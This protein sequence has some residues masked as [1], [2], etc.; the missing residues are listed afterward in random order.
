MPVIDAYGQRR[1]EEVMRDTWGHLG[2]NPG[3]LYRGH[4]VFAHGV[5]GDLVVLEV[6]FGGRA[7]DGPWFYEGLHDWTWDQDTK[8]GCIYRFDG[9]YRLRKD[10]QHDFIGT[11]KELT[12]A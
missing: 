5:Y 6:D 7:D 8:P 2:A 4:I 1:A 12:T 10:N 11:I 3:T 9:T